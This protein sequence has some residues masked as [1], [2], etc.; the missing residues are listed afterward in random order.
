LQNVIPFCQIWL[1]KAL[2]TG[3]FLF[4]RAIPTRSRANPKPFGIVS[5]WTHQKQDAK[6]DYQ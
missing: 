1:N 4:A 2:E 5:E 3:P 6:A